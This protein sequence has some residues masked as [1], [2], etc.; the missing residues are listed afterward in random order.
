MSD[1]KFVHEYVS[2]LAD[3]AVIIAA[4]NRSRPI[5]MQV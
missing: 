2:A 1:W 3:V 5:F 4:A